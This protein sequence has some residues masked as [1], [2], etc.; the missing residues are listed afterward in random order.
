MVVKSKQLAGFDAHYVP[1][2]DC[3]GLPIENQIEKTHGRGLPRDK[4]QALS[5]SLCQGA[6]HAAD[7]RLPAPGRAGRLGQP[8]PHDGP[9][10]RSRRDPR[11]Q[12]P[13]GARLRLPRRQAGVLVFRLRVVAGGIRDRIRRQGLAHGGRGL[14]GA[15]ARQAGCGLR[16]PALHQARVHGDLDHHAVDA[17]GQP[18]AEPEPGLVYALVD[19]ER[20]LF[21][22]AEALVDKP[23]WQR[24]GLAGSV[25]AT[26][27]GE[28]SPASSSTTRWPKPTRAIA[29][30]RRSTWPT[31]PRPKTAPVSCTRRRPMAWKTSTPASR[32]AWARRHPQPRAGRRRL[33]S[34][35]PLFGG[36]HIWKA[37]PQHRGSTGAKPAACWPPARWSTATRTAG[38]TRRR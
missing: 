2:W 34:A 22:V 9:G 36:Q 26:T 31:T 25:L 32:M 38:A 16:L 17:A 29:A 4:V 6:D 20:G 13:D 3:H 15:R 14:P 19:T 10:Q 23:A 35:L 1:G 18:G 11:A 21:M 24:W 33:R 37:N 8:L 27:L 30:R 7:G 5:R 28:S 12:A